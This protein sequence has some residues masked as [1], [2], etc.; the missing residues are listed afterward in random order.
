MLITII[1]PCYNEKNTLEKLIL[2]LNSLKKIKKQ[3]IIIDDGS[4][5]GTTEI[6]KNKLKKKVNKVIFHKKNSGKGSAIKSA[7]KFVQGDIVIIQDADLEYDP[8]DYYKLIKPFENSKVNV[9]YGSRVLGRKKKIY[10]HNLEKIYR[11]FGNFILTK[12]SNYLNKQKLTDAHTCYKLFRKKLFIKLKIQQQDFSFC[13]EVTTKLSLLNE[14]IVEI[15]ISYN[16][17]SYKEGKKIS[18]KDAILTVAAIIKY[19]L[20][21]NV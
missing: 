12:T 4:S 8:K 18:F 21:F 11:I 3:I 6:I 20:K 15:P 19:R 14:N 1:V 9:V 17:R 16:G 7:I 13:A 10:H 2:K 5:D